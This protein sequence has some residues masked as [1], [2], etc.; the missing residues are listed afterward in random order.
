MRVNATKTFYAS[1]SGATNKSVTWLV[2][3]IAGGNATVGTVST[4]GL[5]TAPAVVPSPNVV[6]VRARSVENTAVFAQASVTLQHP[7]P[8]ITSLTPYLVNVGTFSV[9]IAGR[10]FIPRSVVKIG[11]VAVTATYVSDTELRFT[12]TDST[13]RET[14]ITV[15]N[16]DPGADVSNG[17]YF[18]IM[19]PV[20]VSLYPSTYTMRI[21]ATKQLTYSV[22]NAVDKTVTFS[23]NGIAGGNAT[24]GTITADGLYTPPAVLPPAASGAV[25]QVTIAATS[26]QNPA[27][28]DT[29]VFTLQ[30]PLPVITKM[31]PGALLPDAQQ[32]FRI[33]MTGYVSGTSVYVGS[34]KATVLFGTPT[35]VM[36]AAKTPYGLGGVTTVTVR[37]P[38]PGA[39]TSNAIVVPLRPS[40]PQ[41]TPEVAARFLQRASWGP[42]PQSIVQLQQKGITT[43]L[44]EQRTAAISPLPE[45]VVDSSSITPAQRAFYLNAMTGP[46]Q[47][48]Q[49][50]AFA[51]SQ[52]LVV[53]GVKT[54]S[55][56]QLVPYMRMLNQHAFGNYFTLLREVT[57]SPTMGR[58]LDMV[59]NVKANPA[60]GL[61]PNENYGR[62]LLQLFAVGLNLLNM[63]GTNKLDSTG[64]PIPAY[65]EEN[66]KHF[67]RALTGWTYPT[68]PGATP[69][70]INPAYYV[71]PMIAVDENHDKT[72]KTLLN[73]AIIPAGRT[74]PEELDAVIDNLRQ[75]PNVPP[76]VALRLI[77]RLVMGQPSPAYVQR[78]ATRFQQTGGDLWE[79]TKAI[80]T[81][82]EADAVAVSQ[83]KLREPIL[84][85]LSFLRALDAEVTAEHGLNGYANNMGQSLWF[86]PS[87]FN[88]FSPFFRANGVVAPEYQI[89]TPSVALNR[90]NFI[91]RASRNSLGS[92]V[93]IDL[94]E[95]ERLAADPAALLEALNQA[96][97]HGAMSP[98]MKTSILT[99][100]NAATDMRTRARN[101]AYL[102][103]SSSQYQVEP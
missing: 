58:F 8:T 53:S 101:A 60:K 75:H 89:N 80:V 41:I 23:V 48:R 100:L 98:A 44:N 7:E 99:A 97:M 47:L 92:T 79:T 61:E 72:Q 20:T 3:G 84:L 46:D 52:I 95:L 22:G 57:L 17:K 69:R 71:G 65:T 94:E 34:T 50:M 10:G 55:S 73:G 31:T 70:A 63:D 56:H 14:A 93:S 62:E 45:P 6:T 30:N 74:A 39:A 86:A 76:F 42:S 91:Y 36:A 102:V 9:V 28:K 103:G 59:N 4:T 5:Y 25:P 78:V 16:P 40:N 67:A 96:L 2:N 90:V 26:K 33:E 64:K 68:K 11:D 38:D 83:G 19:P 27:I 82:P 35:Y 37:N 12:R 32:T 43:W 29:S 24:Y 85:V 18:K 87:V 77:Q 51:L 54:G 21:G 13:A 1:V 81:D 15:S 49:R 66:V 88:Y